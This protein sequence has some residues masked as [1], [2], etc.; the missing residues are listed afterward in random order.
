VIVADAS[1]VL[2]AL[3]DDGPVG[4]VSR[5][6]LLSEPVRAPELIYCEVTSAVRRLESAGQLS[7]S[8]AAAAIADLVAMP[9]EIAGHRLLTSRC[10]DLRHNVTVYDAAYVALAERSEATLVTS[11]ARLARATGPTCTIELLRT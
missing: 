7:P 9:I 11:D 5:R 2:T 10:W 4:D 8:R 1:I 3:I 6:R